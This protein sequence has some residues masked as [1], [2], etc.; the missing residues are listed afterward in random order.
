MEFMKIEALNLSHQALL[1]KKFN[2]LET[3]ISEY[4][5][6]NIYLFRAIH[7]Y[8]VLMEADEVFVR[9]KTRDNDSFIMLTKHPKFLTADQM[10]FAFSQASFLYPIPQEWI[11]SFAPRMIQIGFREADDDYIY[12]QTKLANYPGRHLDSKRNLVKQL[13]NQHQVN[14][15]DFSDQKLEAEE[16]LAEWQS[17]QESDPNLTD[18]LPCKEAIHLFSHL[19]L[20]GRIVYVDQK[21]AA[22]ALGEWR[23]KECYVVHFTKALRS[24]KGLYQYL[25][26]DLAKSIE[27]RATWINLEQDLGIPS[28]R[29]SKH[30]YLPDQLLRKLRIK[31]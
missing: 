21:P 8:E 15:I 22:F 7:Q 5:F 9:G 12:R 4:S 30:S 19:N 16:I 10:K 13:T 24:I 28:L 29:D 26:Q 1:E 2:Q 31:N 20:H 3:F 18:Y 11:R 25:Y 23:T 17:E 27:G 6:A 14:S